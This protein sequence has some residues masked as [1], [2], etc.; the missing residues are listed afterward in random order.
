MIHRTLE[1]HTW[2]GV[3]LFAWR[4]WDMWL[5]VLPPEG[6]E[7]KGQPHGQYVMEPQQK[8]WAPRLQWASLVGNTLRVLTQMD[9][10][11]IT[12]PWLLRERKTE[13]QPL[14]PFPDSTLM[15]FSPWHFN[16]YSFPIINYRRHYNSFQLVLW[17]LV[18]NYWT[19]EWF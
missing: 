9:A 5:S 8:L 19:W 3:S 17:S 13:A 4:L 15:H 18:A 11:K 12:C 6:L 10:G 1:R 16:L 14:V 2:T 7:S